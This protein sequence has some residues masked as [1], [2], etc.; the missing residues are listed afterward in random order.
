VASTEI[1]TFLPPNS[2]SNIGIFIHLENFTRKTCAQFTEIILGNEANEALLDYVEVT[3]NRNPFYLEQMVEFLKEKDWL[4][5]YHGKWTLNTGEIVTPEKIGNLLTTRIDSLN[6]EL[7]ELCKVAAVI[8]REFD[9]TILETVW[10]A[11]HTDANILVTQIGFI[12][13]LIKAGTREN[14]WRP[15]TKRRFLFQ[16]ALLREAAYSIQLPAT[17]Q[18]I[19]LLVAEAIEG[20]FK[21]HI[22][23]KL[24]ELAYHYELANHIQKASEFLYRAAVQAKSNYLNE[25]A[26]GFLEKLLKNI[27]LHQHHPFRFKALILQGSILEITGY[28][29]RAEK[30]Y[31]QA[32]S[33]L[34]EDYSGELIPI[35][36]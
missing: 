16:H 20:H 4:T 36:F 28:W 2:S 19:H 21:D 25:H 33:S 3:T 7:R 32:Y 6:P 26:L 30:I 27:N 31:L 14:I 18:Q 1:K 12:E 15:L 9:L 35:L 10:K 11:L 13:N 5:T 17:L 24:Q 29:E 8:G 34:N 22:E 23:L